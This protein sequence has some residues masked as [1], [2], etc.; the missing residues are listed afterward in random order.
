[1]MAGLPFLPRALGEAP[2]WIAGAFHGEALAVL[3]A[4]ADAGDATHTVVSDGYGAQ[5]LT[6]PVRAVAERSEVH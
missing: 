6:I 3:R 2:A 4:G 1:M 5:T